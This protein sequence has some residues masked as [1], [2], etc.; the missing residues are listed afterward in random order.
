MANRLS[1]G[2]TVMLRT[3]ECDI[4]QED[5]CAQRSL[6]EVGEKKFHTSYWSS[7]KVLLIIPE[8]VRRPDLKSFRSQVHFEIASRVCMVTYIHTY[9]YGYIHTLDGV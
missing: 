3:E 4:S 9:M 6:A 1:F 2:F 8:G 5:V 7:E